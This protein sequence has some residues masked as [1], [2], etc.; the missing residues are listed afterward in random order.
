M[1]RRQFANGTIDEIG[2][3]RRVSGIQ[4]RLDG[5]EKRVGRVG[6]LP[7]DRLTSDD[8]ELARSRRG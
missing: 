3:V 7:E 6:K 5:R 4:I 2:A 8:D 1:K